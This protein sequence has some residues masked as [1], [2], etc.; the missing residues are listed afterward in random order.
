MAILQNPLLSI[1]ASGTIAGS[2]T[3]ATWKGRPY[4]RQTVTPAN[5]QTGLQ[6]GVRAGMS[7]LSKYW[8][9]LSGTLQAKWNA[10]ASLTSIT[11]LNAFV[12]QN[13]TRNRQDLGLYTDP[14]SHPAVATTGPV[15]TLTATAMPRSVKLA[16]TLNATHPADFCVKVYGSNTTGFTPD[17]SNLLA[18]LPSTTLGFVDTGLVTGLEKFYTAIQNMADGNTSTAI[19]Q[20]NATPT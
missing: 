14:T 4:V 7:F 15:A 17:V 12:A 19:A 16:W 20:V 10:V 8:S 18:I 5:P 1:G 11:G 2:L 3:F 6:T 9:G 13:Q